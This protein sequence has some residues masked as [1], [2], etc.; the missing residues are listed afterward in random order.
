MLKVVR[1]CG[2]RFPGCCAWVTFGLWAG[3]V[4]LIL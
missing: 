3:S 4:V 1:W 2:I